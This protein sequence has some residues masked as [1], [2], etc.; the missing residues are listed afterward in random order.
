MKYNLNK[1]SERLAE[2]RML[3]GLSQQSL[4]KKSGVTRACIWRYEN[5]INIP[6]ADLLSHLATV[7]NVSIDW[8]LG[9]EE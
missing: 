6:R 9:G 7:L 5:G 2:A 4:E 8:L 1:F 3:A